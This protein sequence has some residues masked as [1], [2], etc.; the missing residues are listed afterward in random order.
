MS[1]L[2]LSDKYRPRSIN[3]LILDSII[4]NKIK[5]SNSANREAQDKNF[6][7][8][9]VFHDANFSC[10]CGALNN[11]RN[12]GVTCGKCKSKVIAVT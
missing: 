10:D 3:D 4:F 6:K 11:K 1:L 12:V 9:K 7:S 8:Q 2:P 5:D